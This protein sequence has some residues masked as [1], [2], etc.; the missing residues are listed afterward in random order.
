MMKA[1][2]F[3]AGNHPY[4]TYSYSGGCAQGGRSCPNRA[5]WSLFYG[6]GVSACDGHFL[7]FLRAALR[8]GDH[9]EISR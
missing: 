6:K 7:G 8:K 2:P 9:V 5:S 3:Q 1:R 4:W